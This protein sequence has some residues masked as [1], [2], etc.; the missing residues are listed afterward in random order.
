[1][2]TGQKGKNNPALADILKFE[3]L[4]TALSSE[5]INLPTD[6]LEDK[7]KR[8]LKQV[9]QFLNVDRST[10]FELSENKR[11]IVTICSYSGDGVEPF[12]DKITNRV[13]PWYTEKIIRGD[14][15]VLNRLPDDLPEEAAIEKEYCRRTGMRS[16]L[17]IPIRVADAGSCVIAFGC[18]RTSRKWPRQLLPRLR[19]VGEIFARALVHK[20]SEEKRHQA[21]SEIK[22]L[23]ERLERDCTY[24]QEEVQ[25]EHN[26]KNIIGNSNALKYALLRVDQVAPSEATV[27]IMGETGTGKELIA[28]AIHHA[29]PRRRRPL[30]KLNCAALPPG[31]IESE[32]FGHEKGAFSGS[33]GKRIGRFEYA[34][35]ATLFL[36]EIG[37]LPPDL[38]PKLLRI[39][40]DG[41]F[42]RVGSS[43]TRVCDVR[44]IAATNR[45]LEAAVKAGRFRKDLWF[46]LSV[47]PI[48]VPP[49]RDRRE[50]IPL[51]VRHFVEK[52]AQK[53]GKNIQVMSTSKMDRLHAYEWPGNI[54]EL[55]N[56]IERG[57]I[58]SK[59]T[60]L[61][62]KDIFLTEPKIDSPPYRA[63]NFEEMQRL[64]IINA[65]DRASWKIE[66]PSGAAR[67][68]D[69]KPSTL[70]YRMKKLGIERRTHHLPTK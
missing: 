66:G 43:R 45:D 13:L 67:M 21:L 38:Q 27:L 58:I 56:V 46:R 48:T 37:E 39:I 42:E 63:Q 17:T 6:R 2:V 34:D 51:L 30:V 3:R 19:L 5:F 62:L 54:R 26:F 64:F 1:M 20:R 68:L 15:I 12:D 32:L 60:S 47:F 10:F 70:R 50:D 14:M 69:L 18:F 11:D 23:K 24:L 25:S 29:S 31:I 52:Y 36:D 65:L 53:A 49:L 33:H 28:R 61:Q 59:G 8:G 4:L 40:E 7:I 22:R 44:I 9:V 35:G 55:Q 16:N 41:Q 57:V